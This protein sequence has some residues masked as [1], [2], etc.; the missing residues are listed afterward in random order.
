[1]YTVYMHNHYKFEDSHALYRNVQMF[2]FGIP[3]NAARRPKAVSTS[4]PAPPRSSLAIHESGYH[5]LTTDAP[6]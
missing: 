2:V 5:P 4:Q 1:M 3:T 6:A